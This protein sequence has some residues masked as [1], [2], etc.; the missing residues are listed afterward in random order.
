MKYWRMSFKVGNKGYKMWPH[1]RQLGVAAIT[2]QPL[3]KVNLSMHPQG[4]PKR[5]WDQLKPTQKA[6][7]RRVAYEMT[8]GD[9]IYAKEGTR[10]IDKGIVRGPANKRAYKFDSQ[11]SLKNPHGTPWAH[12]VAV[13]WSSDFSPVRI[14]LGGEQVTVKEL[15]PEEVKQIEKSILK[16][17]KVRNAPSAGKSRTI[18]LLEDAYYR[19]L[20]AQLKFIIP[21]HKKLSNNFC[22]WL[23]MQH[24]IN[25]VKER[26]QIDINFKM[27]ERT[28]L[29]ELKTCYGVGKTTTISKALGQLFQY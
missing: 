17:S 14:L 29:A 8:G 13:D 18:P 5:L 20:K 21:R 7:L 26:Q 19:E 11:F 28:E 1:C 9:V 12:Q 22:K 2:Y 16:S 23:G 6:S 3:T 25:A 10:I 4:E 24:G 27:K 15:S